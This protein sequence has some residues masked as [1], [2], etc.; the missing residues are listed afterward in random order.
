M[1]RMG[2]INC[3][4]LHLILEGVAKLHATLGLVKYKCC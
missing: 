2:I 3:S 4:W 1:I